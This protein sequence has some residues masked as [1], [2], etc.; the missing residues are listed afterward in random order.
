MVETAQ[1]K[2]EDILE[3][4]ARAAENLIASLNVDEKEEVVDIEADKWFY[5]DPQGKIQGPFNDNEM[6]EWY[7]AGYFT[8]DLQ[9]R[10]GRHGA[11]RTLGQ[12]MKAMNTYVPFGP[13]ETVRPPPTPEQLMH[14]TPE[15]YK[16]YIM[17]QQ[18]EQ[19]KEQICN[20]MFNLAQQENYKSMSAVD[21]QHVAA[22]TVQKQQ[23]AGQQISTVSDPSIIHA[24]GPIPSGMRSWPP[25]GPI[26][27]P[28][29]V[30]D[31]E[32]ENR[33]PIQALFQKEYQRRLAL[34][35]I[36]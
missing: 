15:Q 2:T 20:V 28:G 30:W 19:Q 21:L 7:L 29:G 35:R 16:L 5:C 22:Q 27:Q 13:Q 18:Q 14:F 33:D 36:R 11:F 34:V 31:L 25:E 3:D 24:S 8:M 1:V 12:V 32:L 23:H 6:W 17:H 26:R 4:H 9:L 10:K